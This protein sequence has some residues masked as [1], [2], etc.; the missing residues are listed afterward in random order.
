[1]DISPSVEGSKGQGPEAQGPSLSI[2]KVKARGGHLGSGISSTRTS[3]ARHLLLAT[4]AAILACSSFTHAAPA[5]T[6]SAPK[7]TPFPKQ[8]SLAG[9][10]EI[11]NN[12]RIG[13]G[14]VELDATNNIIWYAIFAALGATLLL[15]AFLCS[16][17]CC[18]G[19]R[20]MAEEDPDEPSPMG[21]GGD[22]SRSL[23]RR[24]STAGATVSLPRQL[25][26]PN[27]RQESLPEARGAF[28]EEAL[29]A[30]QDFVQANGNKKEFPVVK[31]HVKQG[32]DEMNLVPGDRIVLTRVFRDGWGEGVSKRAG[33][34]FLFPLVC[35]GG[36]VPRVLVQ[37]LRGHA[38]MQQ[39]QMQMTGLQ[40]TY[41]PQAATRM[42]GGG[43]LPGQPVLATGE[44]S[45]G[46]PEYAYRPPR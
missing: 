3:M 10:P 35:L 22:L 32:S 33:G 38:A 43:V 2:R 42:G 7:I 34:P 25:S 6:V 1:M 39:Q 28:H 5:S 37:R 17:R 12:G 45:Y 19:K 31:V 41:P 11:G 9:L 26:K 20:P 14:P 46:K 16:F 29:A 13:A 23:S 40:Q 4:S 18:G 21:S 36:S 44:D 8:Q 15:L 27:P 30:A 24:R